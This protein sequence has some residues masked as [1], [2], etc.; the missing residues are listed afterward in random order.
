M[1]NHIGEVAFEGSYEQLTET[2]KNPD[3]AFRQ[4]VSL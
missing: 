1:I 3:E 4:I 2:N